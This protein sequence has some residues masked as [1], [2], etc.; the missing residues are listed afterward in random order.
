[1]KQELQINSFNDELFKQDI[2]KILDD[3]STIEDK[4]IEN[5]KNKMVELFTYLSNNIW[6]V[7]KYENFRNM[8]IF[9]AREFK[10]KQSEHQ[11][12]FNICNKFLLQLEE[13]ENDPKLDLHKEMENIICEDGNSVY[14]NLLRSKIIVKINKVFKGFDRD[15]LSE[16]IFKNKKFP[17]GEE[18]KYTDTEIVKNTLIDFF[19]LIN[20][21]DD[22]YILI[23]YETKTFIK[24]YR[25]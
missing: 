15:E 20:T 24:K 22:T 21:G 7:N 4:D 13:A 10:L 14:E 2:K 23:P 3:F 11:D 6:F 18:I 19:E 9:K 16:E 5:K 17:S 8:S 25:I 1:M 12:L